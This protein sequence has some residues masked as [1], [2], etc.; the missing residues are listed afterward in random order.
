MTATNQLDIEQVS[1]PAAVRPARHIVVSATFTAEPVQDILDF[2]MRE[3]NLP[4]AVEFAPYDQVFQQLLDPGSALSQNRQGVNVALVR[5]EDWVRSHVGPGRYQEL[6]ESLARNAADLVN[7]ARGAVACSTAP[8]IIG[9]CPASPAARDDRD[10]LALFTRIEDWIVGELEPVSGICLLGPADFDLYPIADYY[11]LRRDQLGHIPYTPAL[12]AALG[13]ILSRKV[14]SLINPPHKVVVLDCDNTLWKGVIGEEGV[15]GITIPPAW[16]ALQRFM[17]KLAGQGFLL[18]LCSKNDEPDVLDV[19]DRRPDMILKREHLV[20]WRINWQPKSQNIRALAHELNLGLDSF[21]FID[22]NPIEC[23][24]VR[25]ECPEVLTLQ[26]PID[27]DIERF[28]RHVWAFDR[29][30]VTSEDRH[31]TTMYKQEADR[32]RFQRDAPTIDEFL[33]GLDLRITISEPAP[34]QVDRVAQLTQRTNQFNFTTI[35]RNDG[36]I[37]RLAESGLEC[38]AVEVR[39]RFGDYGLV[40]VMIFGCRGAE[41]EVDTFL[42]SC[43]VLGRGVEH[44]MLDEL[45]E[46]ARRRQMSQIAAT[47]IPTKKNQPAR[48]FLEWVA[49]SA[50]QQVEGGWRYEVPVET[51]ATVAYSQGATHGER[52]T[53]GEVTEAARTASDAG[54]PGGKSQ[55]F[56]RIANELVL[57]EQVIQAVNTPSAR[58]RPRPALSQLLIPPR[59]AI[60][61]ELAEI[62]VEVLRLEKVGIQDNY[63]DLGGTSLL[64]VDLFA[65]IEHRFGEKLP[66]TSLIE[67]STIE[68]LARIVVG[69]ADQDSLVLIREGGDRPPLFLV[70]DGDGEIMLYRNLA[71]HLKSDHAV[72]GLQPHSRPD[73]PLAHIRVAEMAAYHIDKMRSVQPQGPYLVGGMCAG[74]VIAFEIALQLQCASEKVALVALI[75]AA[76]VSA[77][78]KAWRFASQRVR[79]FTSAFHHDRSIRFDRRVLPAL[80][81]ALGKAKNLSTYLVRHRLKILRDQIRM[82]LFRSCLDRGWN[83]PRALQQIPVRT[84]Y[85]FAERNY[86]PKGPF[87]GD[88]VLF[89]ATCG[90][91]NDEPY[92][93]RYE[94]PLLGWGQRARGRVRAHDIPGGHSSMLQEP[95]VQIL[96]DQLQLSIDEALIDEP[97]FLHD[98]AVADSIRHASQPVPTT[99]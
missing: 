3:L 67:A 76:D 81:K 8:L 27:G 91:G 35:R 94:D 51:A 5:L 59:T 87:N 17:L 96:A 61:A 48:D 93:E 44:R 10:A 57:P 74:G 60:E 32:A 46:I 53:V 49:G 78:L 68:Q 88:L 52:P 18:C 98:S 55:L 72:Y 85:L 56:E 65:R 12:F 62:W 90:E 99:R 36:E 43:R 84:V 70:H 30:R 34:E 54:T 66:L 1:E 22:D 82:R 89:R 41:L 64:A 45:G 40:G 29:H 50:S 6:E 80:T 33:A 95:Y 24:E 92:I 79:G 97:A 75:D 13:T 47:L 2:W 20:S 77:P 4:A 71:L 58:C 31:R 15:T 28:L 38:R 11:D 21:I 39:D 86:Q 9:L 16:M 26:L 37:R 25:A 73:V 23:A 42:L 83:L 14:R 63:F 69:A 19:F 7:A